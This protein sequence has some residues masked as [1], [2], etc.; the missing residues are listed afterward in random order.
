MIS[1]GSRRRCST[2]PLRSY[3]ARW[4][5]S[6]PLL[7]TEESEHQ[8]IL[9]TAVQQDALPQDALA[10]CAELLGDTAAAGVP[11]G[12]HD[13]EPNQIRP[14]EHP[15]SHRAGGAGREPFRS[16]R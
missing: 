11:H 8:R 4:L 12:D 1:A 14:S 2:K 6:V 13:L 15:G 7:R 9:G 5:M 16:L 3:S 10:P